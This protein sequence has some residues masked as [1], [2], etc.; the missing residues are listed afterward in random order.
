MRQV[1]VLSLASVAFVLGITSGALATDY[2]FTTIDFPGSIETQPTGINSAGTVVGRFVVP[3]GGGT[4]PAGSFSWTSS[5]GFDV[6]SQG[7]APYGTYNGNLD[8]LAVKGIND[9]GQVV[10]SSGLGGYAC[11]GCKYTGTPGSYTGGFGGPSF[12]GAQQTYGMAINNLGNVVI[13]EGNFF[14]NPKVFAGG[15]T[16][17]FTDLSSIF[18]NPSS[19]TGTIGMGINDAG[20]VVGSNGTPLG[21]EGVLISGSTVVRFQEPLSNI[22]YTQATGINNAGQIVGNYSGPSPDGGGGGGYVLS[23][24]TFTEFNVPGSHS[25]VATGINNLGQL[26]GYYT[27]PGSGIYHGFVA[28]PVGPGVTPDSPILPT[29][30]MPAPPGSFIFT[31]TDVLPGLIRFYDPAFAIGY[32]FDIVSGP[33]FQSVM[34]PNVGSGLFD[35]YLFDGT[36]FVFNSILTAGVPFDLGPRGV[37]RFRILGIDPS[38]GLDPTDPTAFVTGLSFT[39]SDTANFTMTPLT[40]GTPSVP[41]PSTWLLFGSGLAGLAAWRRMKKA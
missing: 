5:G 29:P 40:T 19:P 4:F 23:G 6:F 32:D 31:S 15:H 16:V 20:Q 2:T 36:D 3:L 39:G 27:V 22:H 14:G 9:R 11:V 24:T 34:L 41:E 21:S 1:R 8:V 17:G 30:S 35:L 38:A 7:S 37:D 18:Q 13:L 10:G 25:T 28:T 26:V 12:P 33:L